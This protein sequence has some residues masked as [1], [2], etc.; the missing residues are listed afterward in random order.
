MK[1]PVEI[2]KEVMESSQFPFDDIFLDSIPENELDSSDKT[3]ILLTESSSQLGDYGNSNF[4]S[5]LYGVYIQIFYT[6]AENS[7]IDIIKN[8]IELM[9]YL[10][11]NDWLI[12]QSQ[13]HYLDPTTKQM[14][15]NITV[16]RT[17]TLSE[18]ANS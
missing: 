16:Q 9:K 5:L 12:V 4:T 14:I 7:D 10:V 11:E 6:N 13:A 8:E 15:K 1:R 2:V 17:M 18:I 3:Q